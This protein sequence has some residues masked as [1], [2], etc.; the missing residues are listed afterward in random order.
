MKKPGAKTRGGRTVI[1]LSPADAAVYE[2]MK[3]IPLPPGGMLLLGPQSVKILS[4]EGMF[5]GHL[6]DKFIIPESEW[7]TANVKPKGRGSETG[8]KRRP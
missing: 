6:P 5:N 2:V 1:Q 7:R 3:D 4:T 8:R